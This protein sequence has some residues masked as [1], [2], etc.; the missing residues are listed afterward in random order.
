MDV[1]QNILLQ[2]DL[3]EYVIKTKKQIKLT[4]DDVK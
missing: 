2:N 4:F 1:M 3:F